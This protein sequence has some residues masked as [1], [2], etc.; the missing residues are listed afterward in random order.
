MATG[1]FG[2]LRPIRIRGS[3]MEGFHPGLRFAPPWATIRRRFAARLLI[4]IPLPRLGY[5][6]SSGRLFG[7]SKALGERYR[8]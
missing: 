8:G 7:G 2:F 1:L 6:S 3:R 4:R 5:Y